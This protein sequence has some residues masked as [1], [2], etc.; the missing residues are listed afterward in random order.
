MSLFQIRVQTGLV[1]FVSERNIHTV[2]LK[3][4]FLYSTVYIILFYSIFFVFYTFQLYS[5]GILHFLH[6]YIFSTVHVHF[7]CKGLDL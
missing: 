4:I 5:V 1:S 7:Y 3:T 2:L 6:P